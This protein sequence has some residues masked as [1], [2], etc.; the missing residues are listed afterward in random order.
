MRFS[1]QEYWSGLPFLSPGEAGSCSDGRA[2][3]SISLIQ[4]SVDG[5]TCVPSLLLTWVQISEELMKI[6]ATSFKRSHACTAILSAHNPAAGPRLPTSPLETHGHS[7]ASLGQCLVGSLLLSP[8]S[9]CIQGPV[10]PSKS[11]FPILCKFWWLYGG[12]NSNLLQ[13]GLCHIHLCCTQSPCPCGSPLLT[14]TSTGDAQTQFCLSL[15][16]VPGSWCTQGLFEPSEHLWREWGL[17]LNVNLPLLPSFWGSSFALGCW[18]SPQSCSSTRKLPLQHLP[19]YQGF[20]DFGCGVSHHG[21]P[22]EVQQLCVPVPRSHCML[23]N[24]ER[25]GN[26]RPPDPPLEK[27]MCHQEATVRTGH[28]TID[29]FQIGKGVH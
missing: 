25:D 12:V 8:G 4:F 3:I 29:W 18:V 11:L 24:S 21:H 6:M 22:S 23:E 13:V 10:V 17:I 20:S 19:S 2:R 15:S 5:W 28:G 27:S 1:R 26:T 9:W 7:W 16:G 14:C